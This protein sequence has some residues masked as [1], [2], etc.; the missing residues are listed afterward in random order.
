MRT[1]ESKVN[2]PE[3]PETVIKV[4][5]ASDHVAT[6]IGL[7]NYLVS[8]FKIVGEGSFGDSSFQFRE[9]EFRIP[10]AFPFYLLRSSGIH[11]LLY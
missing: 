1:F 4:E 9:S 5:N 10:S 3:N 2:H 8:R 7:Q 11:S 6:C